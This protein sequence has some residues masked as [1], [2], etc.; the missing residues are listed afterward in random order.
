MES[1]QS[2]R[3]EPPM[4]VMALWVL[5]CLGMWFWAI[6]GP[7]NVVL[8]ALSF[9]FDLSNVIDIFGT[10]VQTTGQKAVYLSVSAALAILGVGF[11]WLRRRGY[12]KFF[13]EA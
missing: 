8:G 12:L 1:R 6:I 10:P 13:P 2:Q 7:L 3:G 4:I 5:L 9:F 11:V